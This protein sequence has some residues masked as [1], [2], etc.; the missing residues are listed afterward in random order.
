MPA[1]GPSVGVQALRPHLAGDQDAVALGQG[2]GGVLG[3]RSP[4]LAV[5]V[6]GGA[7]D[8]G[9]GG[10]LVAGVADHAEVDDGPAAGGEPQVGVGREVAGEGDG[11]ARS[12]RA[13]PCPHGR[14][15]FASRGGSRVVRAGQ[16]AACPR[17][18]LQ[19]RWRLRGPGRPRRRRHGMRSTLEA[20]GTA[21]EPVRPVSRPLVAAP[22][23][24]RNP[25]ARGGCRCRR[26]DWWRRPPVAVRRSVAPD[27]ASGLPCA[28]GCRSE[29]GRDGAADQAAA[30]RRGSAAGRR[31]P[32]RARRADAAADGRGCRVRLRRRPSPP[33][34][35]PRRRGRT[36]DGLGRG[37]HDGRRAVGPG[38]H[39]RSAR[40]RG[41]HPWC[42]GREAA[43]QAGRR[44]ASRRGP[45]GCRRGADGRGASGPPG[46][47]D[48]CRL[49]G[50]ADLV[51]FARGRAVPFWWAPLPAALRVS[52]ARDELGR[53]LR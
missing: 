17:G 38:R 1:F 34:R 11:A 10:V 53:R 43:R 29:G 42:R 21:P 13:P 18:L 45:G 40:R 12:W 31:I 6:H 20:G 25:G 16:V 50:A 23:R 9:A 37:G 47:R 28:S 32:R 7:V 35:L 36:A 44:R 39:R 3:E 14:R 33:A 51:S 52:P 4:G 49:G 8:P 19:G 46:D 30:T 15:A 22:P 5:P 24:R 26:R 48:A 41:R 2:L 27:G